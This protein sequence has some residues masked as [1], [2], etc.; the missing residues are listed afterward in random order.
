MEDERDGDDAVRRLD[1][2]EFG[3]KGRKLRVEWAKEERGRRHES[4]R[5]STNS[6]RISKTLFV[7]NFDPYHTRTRDLERHFEPY[8]K[9][10]NIRIRRNFAFIQFETQEDATKA[11]DATHLSKVMD[12]V[13]TVEYAIKDDD[14]GDRRNGRS[15][16][17][18]RDKFQRRDGNDRDR[19]R[20]P[21]RRERA[22]PDYGGVH[23]SSPD[24][25]RGHRSSP[26]HRERHSPD[27][28]CRPG[29]SPANRRK[30]IESACDRSPNVRKRR[31]SGNGSAS[32]LSPVQER[33]GPGNAR[34]RS[35]NNSG[36]D[37]ERAC[38]R[39]PDASRNERYVGRDKA[40]SLRPMRESYSL[41]PI[42]DMAGPDRS[43]NHRRDVEWAHDH[44]PN[45]RG[46]NFERA[47]DRSP[48]HRGRNVEQGRNLSPN[49]RGRDSERA[50]DRS[51]NHRGRDVRDCSPHHRGRDSEQASD[52]SPNHRGRDVERGAHDRSPNHRGRDVERARDCSPHHRGRDSD[53]ASDRSPNHRGRDVER[54]THDR[55]PNHRG[56]DVEQA[57]DCS[58][59]PR[60][61]DVEQA[62]DRS[63]Y[64]RGRDV[65][66]PHHSPNH[67]GRDVEQ[68]RDLSPDICMER[69]GPENGHA[70]SPPE[71]GGPEYPHGHSPS[72]QREDQEKSSHLGGIE[73]P[74][75]N[76]KIYDPEFRRESQSPH[77]IY[78]SR[79]SSS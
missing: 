1:R 45:H 20:S 44:S 8:G 12:R 35:P 4:T 52:R 26:Y 47:C 29:S 36:R 41:S 5:R 60:G 25:G 17:R 64:Y 53:Q 39:S 37:F 7:I 16:D 33:A 72:P 21:Y 31:Y 48:N 73:V 58:P 15:P 65:E 3:R 40:P 71:R 46:S 11:L 74:G 42:R 22:S 50:L 34:E 70:N 79:S 78:K 55:S 69:A 63:P 49:H 75:L 66:R 43:P 24:Y 19:S 59:H 32:S 14:M 2:M 38:N 18:G 23:R 54:G 57:R 67:R 62:S 51:P 28:G 68:A 10:L 61:R 6:T 76:P 77:E 30:E 56:R 27:Y 9:I 13:I